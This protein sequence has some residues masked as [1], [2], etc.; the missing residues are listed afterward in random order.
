MG[1]ADYF[2]PVKV[3]SAEEVR[4]FL[5]K[6]DSGEYNLVDVR[7]PKEYERGHIPG[8]KLIPVGEI[9]DRG[10]ELDSAKPTITYCGSGMRS[11]AAASALAEI[12]FDDV[13]SM[14]GGIRAWEGLTASGVPESGMAYFESAADPEK[15]IALAWILEDG[16]KKFYSSVPEIIKDEDAVK[17]FKNL[18]NAEEHHKKTLFDLYSDLTGEKPSGDFPQPLIKDK[19]LHDIMEGGMQVSEALEWVKGKNISD[20]LELAISLEANAY[21]LYLKLKHRMSDERTKKIFDV[22]SSEEKKHLE[23][24]AKLLERKI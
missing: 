13:F 17:L 10:G 3:M 1:V 21:D 22:L 4:E 23:Q 14:S 12:G 20:V 11:R 19:S 18:A 6:K 15:L 7:Q 16:S 5:K 9:S 2:K 24:F 8:A